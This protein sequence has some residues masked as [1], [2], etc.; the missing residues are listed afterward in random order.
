MPLPSFAKHVEQTA[1]LARRTALECVMLVNVCLDTLSSAP[2]RHVEPAA[3]R[4]HHV[5]QTALVC[6]TANHRVQPTHSSTPIPK[7]AKHVIPI[8]NHALKLEPRSVMLENA[9]QRLV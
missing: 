9:C 8:A 6:V 3:L 2:L 1:I 7:L 4:V 5:L